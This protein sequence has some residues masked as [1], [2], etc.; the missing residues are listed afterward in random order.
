M[1]AGK[2][3]RLVTYQT[4]VY[5]RNKHNQADISDW[6]TVGSFRAE[7]RPMSGRE[8]ILA[9]QFRATATHVVS[10]R[11]PGFMYSP[12]GRFIYSDTSSGVHIFN[13]THVHNIDNR[14]R[15]IDTYC[16][17]VVSPVTRS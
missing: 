15:Q 8:A 6:T 1:R 4:P 2:L 7:I 14:N 3:F 16:T 9:E 17:E 13:I 5:A 11:Y 12:A 10:T